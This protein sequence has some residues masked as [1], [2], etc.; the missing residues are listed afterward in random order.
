MNPSLRNP[1]RHVPAY[2]RLHTRW[3]WLLGR[4]HRGG[5]EAAM[6][7]FADMPDELQRF[8]LAEC[9][10]AQVQA[11]E[12]LRVTILQAFKVALRAQP[13][14]DG[15]GDDEPEEDVADHGGDEATDGAP[16]PPE[17]A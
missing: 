7:D 4:Q 9:A 2:Q 1:K 17:A 12:E 14:A 13:E 15:V 3:G 10:F 8:V 16:E 6:A 11:T 5:R